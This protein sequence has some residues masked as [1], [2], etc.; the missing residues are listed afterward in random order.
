[1]ED[2]TF[3]CMGLLGVPFITPK[4]TE[5]WRCSGCTELTATLLRTLQLCKKDY[6]DSVDN[7][8]RLLECITPGVSKMLYIS[9][10]AEIKNLTE[11]SIFEN[12]ITCCMTKQTVQARNTV[13]KMLY[14]SLGAEIKNPTEQ[15]I[16]ENI[17][18][19]E[20][21]TTKLH[22]IRQEPGQP[23]QSFLANLKSKA[24]QCDMKLTCSNPTCLT[25][26]NISEQVILGLFINRM[27]GMELQQDLLAE[28][29]LMLNKAV[30]KAVAHE[31][32]KRSQGILETSQQVV[33]GISTYKKGL[34]K[35]VV[36]TDCCSN[37]QHSDRNDCP[38]KDNMC[39]GFSENIATEM[40]RK[41]TH[42]VVVERRPPRK[43]RQTPR[44]RLATASASTASACRPRWRPIGVPAAA[45]ALSSLHQ[46]CPPSTSQRR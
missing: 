7:P 23:V 22:R 5:P 20:A 19:L 40:A 21:R 45:L 46:Q 4:L 3:T 39:R 32:D 9:L 29:N 18:A 41:E 12:I 44:R 11:H 16:F 8:A 10:R 36:P 25:E 17:I 43:M 15:G 30:T 37:K 2:T 31:T 27:S 42:R 28:Q 38:A 34:N 1:M 14:S 33:T 26:L 6:V 13:S 24:R 35:V